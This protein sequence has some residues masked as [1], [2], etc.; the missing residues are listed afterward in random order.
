MKLHSKR[1]DKNHGDY[2]ADNM[3]ICSELDFNL[4][5]ISQLS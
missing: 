2:H 3:I 1:I 5:H 4:L